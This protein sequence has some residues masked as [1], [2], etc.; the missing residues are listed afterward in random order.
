MKHHET[1]N[2]TII[3]Q[4][5]KNEFREEF[6]QRI[7]EQIRLLLE[8][9]Y[10]VVVRCDDLGHEIVIIEFEHDNNFVNYGC[11]QPVW[12]TPEEEKRLFSMDEDTEED[13]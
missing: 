10:L 1:I 7:S 3:F 12:I 13:N 2:E 5:K 6:F 4:K 11:S 9:E 8:E